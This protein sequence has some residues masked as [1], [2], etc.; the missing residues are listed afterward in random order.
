MSIH[1]CKT[2][3]YGNSWRGEE[4]RESLITFIILTHSDTSCLRFDTNSHWY[5]HWC[6]VNLMT[7]SIFLSTLTT[8]PAVVTFRLKNIYSVFQFNTIKNVISVLVNIDHC[9]QSYSQHQRNWKMR[10]VED[11]TGYQTLALVFE[12]FFLRPT[13]VSKQ[14]CSTEPVP[15]TYLP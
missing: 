5:K 7:S 13:S 9:S 3:H 6:L 4:H 11:M 1:S 14:H 2:A 15:S 8:V 12:P 10:T